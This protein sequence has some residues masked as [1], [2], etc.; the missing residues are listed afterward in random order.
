MTRT[1][2]DFGIDLGTT[3]SCVA[4]L[5]GTKPRVIPNQEGAAYTP[6]AVWID[7]R[8]QLRVGREAKER[9]DSDDQ[10]VAVEFKL[11][12]GS[13]APRTF[14]SSNRS[15]KPE[16]LSAEVLKSL[17][18][19][20]RASLREDVRAAVITV[21]A[22]FELPQCDATRKAAEF[23]G[24]GMTP[25]LQEPVA[26]ALAY[27][28]Q[29]ESDRVFW[30]VFDFGGG[31]F[32]A[33]VIQVRDGR[34]EVVNHAGDNHLGGKKLDWAI[35]ESKLVPAVLAKHHL[36]DFSRNN[37]RWK[38]AFAMLKLE[39]EKAKIQVSRTGEP[40][41]IFVDKLMDAETGKLFD[42]EYALTP[43]DLEEVAEPF[44]AQAVE[45]CRRALT[46]SR[47][48]GR[49][50][51]KVIM[52]GGTSLLPSLQRQVQEELQVTLDY[53][54]DP[55]TIVAQGAAI[56]A[57][58]Q[59]L[60]QEIGDLPPGVC[61]IELEYQPIGSELTVP[62]GGRVVPPDGRKTEGFSL[63][64]VEKRSQWRSGLVRLTPKGA[65][66]L[67][68][69]AEK[70]R[71][72]E[73]DIELYD[74][75][76]GRQ[77]C[78]PDRFTY[79]VGLV[80]DDAPLTH[81]VGVAQANNRVDPF[82]KK[83]TPLP[84]SPHREIHRVV[85]GVRRGENNDVINIPVVEGEN[86]ERADRNRKIGALVISGEAIKR[87]V[88]ADAEIE[89]TIQIDASRLVTTS[90]YIPIL[91][92]EF[93]APL[94]LQKQV[95][96]PAQLQEDLRRERDR[97]QRI[98]EQNRGA[99][100]L[101]AQDAVNRIEREE[102]VGQVERLANAAEAD[103][104]SAIA[105]ENRLLDLRMALDEAEESLEWPTQVNEAQE[106][107]SNVRGIV[108][109]HGD[110]DDKRRMQAIENDMDR[111]IQ[112]NDPDLVRNVREH[113]A[114]LAVRVLDRQPGF[115]IGLLEHLAG[116]QGSMRDSSLASQL[117]AQGR[118]C[119]DQNDVD[120]LRAACRQLMTLLP[121]EQQQ[122]LPGFGGTTLRG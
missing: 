80:I 72:C 47:L 4:V 73:Y 89:I 28:F 118:R 55:L 11:L 30:L 1:T 40:V 34:I 12:M 48:S 26:A 3:N 54:I 100:N 63:R 70:G 69:H 35:V 33:A 31:T 5:D 60:P 2:I 86:L 82:F 6:S 107:L 76:G 62:V 97:L 32:D 42:L 49:D 85:R 67:E 25:L 58:S 46:E 104:E 23:A 20:V 78:A 87:D 16:D 10:D 98:R 59:R 111:A 112:S 50:L 115:W 90:A 56:F 95:P 18:N 37:I 83:G 77:P 27:G 68:I 101:R 114:S 22:A 17:R 66:L 102:M 106:Q 41:E 94:S 91:D 52:V 120:G 19:D 116:Q 51:Q 45:L 65:F 108:D 13:G 99:R 105:G 96:S 9:S 38:S 43:K 21:P 122:Q 81:S 117:V 79:K 29:D 109:E 110:A 39:A 24:F 103:P 53:S 119:I 7:R 8:G 71:E 121:V 75:S 113:V 36:A 44:V 93:Q 92:Q 14:K 57:G 84:T 15:M 61:R 88:P 74:A 64:I